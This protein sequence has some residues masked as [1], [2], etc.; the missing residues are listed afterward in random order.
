MTSVSDWQNGQVLARHIYIKRIDTGG[1]LS[2]PNIDTFQYLAKSAVALLSDADSNGVVDEVELGD[3]SSAD[4]IIN[5]VDEVAMID[6]VVITLHMVAT[7][8]QGM[9]MRQ[10]LSTQITPRSMQLYRINGIVGL[11]D[12]TDP[13]QID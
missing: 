11:A 8:T 5:H 12:A 3:L 1:S 7:G 2:A 9:I 13:T 10:S 6:S 4:D